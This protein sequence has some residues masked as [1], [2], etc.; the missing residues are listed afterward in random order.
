[1]KIKIDT[2]LKESFLPKDYRR[3]FISLIKAAFEEGDNLFYQRL[4]ESS[5]PVDKPFTFSV[6]FPELKQSNNE[7]LEV[8]NK[9]IINLSS[10]AP[11]LLTHLYNGARK[12]KFHKWGDK[13]EFT[14]ENISAFFNKK[15]NKNHVYF[16]TIAPFLINSKG[17]KS[18]YLKPE[19]EEFDHG[20]RHSINELSRKFLAIPDIDFEYKIH[21]HKSMVVSHYNQSMTCNKGIIEMHA[22]PQ[23]LDLINNIG[24]GVRRSQGF[25]M[26]EMI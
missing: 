19:D 2:T 25:G 15:V 24:I 9:A 22:E 16:R 10:N 23:V 11:E 8:G 18:K 13:N 26:V 7:H 20:F 17:N 1:M 4:Y 14:I 21:K 12:L 5:E 3:A 6:Y